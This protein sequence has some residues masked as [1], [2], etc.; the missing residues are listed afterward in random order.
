MRITFCG[1]A[2]EVTGS[3]HLLETSNTRLL[4]DCGLF[5]GSSFCEAKNYEAFPFD[6]SSIDAVV[7]THAHLDH[8]GR[9]PKLVREGFRGSVY[10]TAP[11][12][13]LA[14]VSLEDAYNIMKE[15]RKRFGTP[16]MYEPHDLEEALNR[17]VPLGYSRAQEFGELKIRLREAGHIFGS[18]FVECFE[19]GGARVA[20]SGDLGNEHVP[21][22]RETAQL[23]E[24]DAVIME[25]TYGDRHHDDEHTRVARLK[26]AIE[27]VIASKGVL[28]IPA[29][30]IERTQQLLYELNDLV[31]TKQLPKVDVYLDSPMAIKATE[32]MRKFPQFYD[33]EA[34]RRVSHGDDIF[35]FP[36]LRLCMDRDA[37]KA[38]ND[39][40]KPKVIISGSGMMNA[41]RIQH[42]LVR[43][44][45]DESTVVLVVGYQAPNTLGRKLL[46]GEKRV[47]IL[48]ERVEVRAD[49]RKIGAYS[50]HADQPKLVRWIR[51]AASKP[52]HVYCVHGEEASAETL[53]SVLTQEAGVEASVPAYGESI[54][55]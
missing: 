9:L 4:I 34:F 41:G 18:A 11:T 8:I 46:E 24:M 3:C 5:Q 14:K 36:G 54:K 12:A 37:S 43:Y 33:P 27:A 31:E 48:D 52:S 1:A 2:R 26:E 25:S 23:A 30:A 22:L 29:F 20:F 7:L 28:I 6:P 55:L 38:I 47:K 15:E 35:D 16:I 39:A 32:V 19:H 45:S 17:F 21:I 50:A 53:A 44:L 42:H 13:A 51:D 40:P 49:I 10:T